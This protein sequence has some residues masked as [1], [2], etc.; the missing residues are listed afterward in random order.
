MMT[1]NPAAHKISDYLACRAFRK[2]GLSEI[3][4]VTR[5][6]INFP[7][8]LLSLPGHEGNYRSSGAYGFSEKDFVAGSVTGYRKLNFDAESGTLSGQLDNVFEEHLETFDGW[9][10][11]KCLP[12]FGNLY[13]SNKS[14]HAIPADECACGWWGYWDAASAVSHYIY[15]I[16][17][18]GQP[19]CVPVVAAVE[20]AGN[21]IL[22][23]KGFRSSLMRIRSIAPVS[24]SEESLELLRKS[25]YEVAYSPVELAKAYPADPN[26]SSMA[27]RAPELWEYSAAELTHYWHVIS[28]I[29]EW[30]ENQHYDIFNNY[31]TLY[32]MSLSE[33]NS[34]LETD[35]YKTQAYTEAAISAK[36]EE[37]RVTRVIQE[38]GGLYK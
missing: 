22:G 16:K 1:K 34:V 13:V 23:E 4:R 12:P 9:R 28:A 10:K 31:K 17:G 29:A 6:S 26:Y 24:A 3:A 38:K 25:A 5:L 27:F 2:C 7:C 30:A 14:G 18:L 32:S 8:Y 35:M 36:T 15:A 37:E 19:E 11:A 21:T 33:T 20:G